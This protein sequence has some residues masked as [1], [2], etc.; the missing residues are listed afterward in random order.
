[1]FARVFE[2]AQGDLGPPIDFN[3]MAKGM[4][5]GYVGTGILSAKFFMQVINADGSLGAFKIDG[6]NSAILQID[7]LIISY[8]WTGTDTDTLT[9]TRG[10]ASFMRGYWGAAS[11]LPRTF[12]GP[13]VFV[14]LAGTK[15]VH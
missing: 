3:V 8:A 10:Y 6:A 7:P 2:I 4:R 14:Y 13:E 5:T 12:D 1:M 9:L 15:L 11:T